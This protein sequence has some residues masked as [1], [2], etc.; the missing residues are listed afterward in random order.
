M[1][2]AI[3]VADE[4]LAPGLFDEPHDDVGDTAPTGKAKEDVPKRG[5]VRIRA[6][7]GG[8]ADVI[9]DCT[10]LSLIALSQAA[11][12]GGAAYLVFSLFA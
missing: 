6:A 3:A 8:V 5:E 10:I 9:H 7:T 2:A 12:V 1:T 4:L 11:W